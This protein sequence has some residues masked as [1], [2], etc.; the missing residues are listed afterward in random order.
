MVDVTGDGALAASEVAAAAPPPYCAC[1]GFCR[2][3]LHF[4]ADETPVGAV[5]VS[6]P[7]ETVEGK[8]L[9]DQQLAPVYTAAVYHSKVTRS[10]R[11]GRAT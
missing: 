1:T 8:E 4:M 7:R 11:R 5:V 6:F 10:V 3:H 2:D 9:S